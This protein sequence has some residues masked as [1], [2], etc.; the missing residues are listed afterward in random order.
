[1]LLIQKQLLF[2]LGSILILT[3]VQMVL[4][5]QCVPSLEDN[6]NHFFPSALPGRNLVVLKPKPAR[7]M[8]HYHSETHR[9]CPNTDGQESNFAHFDLSL[10]WDQSTESS[11]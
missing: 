1:M 6:D 8:T 10:I 4:E 2:T 11:L 5:S 7:I 3:H 9:S